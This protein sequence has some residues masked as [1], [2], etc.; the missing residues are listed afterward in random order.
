M[1]KFIKLIDTAIPIPVEN[2]DTDQIIPSRFLK[3]NDRKEL[4]KNLFIDWKRNDNNFP[5]NNSCFSGSILISKKNFGCGSSREHAVWA[6]LDY[7]FKV[8]IANS[9]AD[10]FKENSLNN[11]LLIVEITDNFL[12]KLLSV[13]KKNPKKKIEVD[14]FNQKI[15]FKEKNKIFFEKFY[16]N[17]Y[18]K[19]CFINGYDDIDFLISI[20]RE[21]KKFEKN[22]N[23]IL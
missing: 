21:I 16:I 17:P 4:G 7:G 1:K 9:F 23:Y 18:K 11:G 15:S 8:V 6:I 5:L 3:I 2:I 10:I 20:K 13:I 19:N 14:L 22:N 12:E